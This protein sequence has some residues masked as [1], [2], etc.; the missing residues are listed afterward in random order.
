MVLIVAAARRLMMS[1]SEPDPPSHSV[2]SND[3]DSRD[4]DDLS[5]ESGSNKVLITANLKPTYNN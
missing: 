4:R 1:G 5:P 3:A 2:D